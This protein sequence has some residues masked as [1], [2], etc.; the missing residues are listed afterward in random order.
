MSKKVTSVQTKK[1]TP[2][3]AKK[4][5]STLGLNLRKVPLKQ[6][7]YGMNVELEHGYINR[8]TN[9][10]D[11][12]LLLTAKIALAHLLEY[13]DYYVRLKKMETT[14]KK[15]WSGKKIDILKH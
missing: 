15:E 12:D 1:I 14:A 10:T 2:I 6:W 4:M 8:L 3:Q 9:V 7:T 11:D 5:A 13:P